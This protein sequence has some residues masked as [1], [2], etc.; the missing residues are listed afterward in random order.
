LNEKQSEY[1][2]DI[3]NS[4]T[5]LLRLIND[6]LDLAKV[7]TGK[8]ELFTETF[9]VKSSIDE[10]RSVIS[11][12]AKKKNIQLVIDIADNV[13]DIIAD[14]QKLKQVLYNLLSNAVKFTPDHG[15][16]EIIVTLNNKSILFQ[17]RDNG[18]GIEMEDLKHLFLPFIQLD[19]GVS[20]KH[21]GTGLGL[22][23]TK[24]L[25]EL[26]NG[27][28]GVQSEL[29]KGSMFTVVLPQLHVK[30]MELELTA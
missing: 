19:S 26:Q 14:K 12:L 27:T 2:N 21:E 9:S 17:I 16:V 20:R 5:H 29:G 4:G 7:E 28:V 15:K 3:L 8:M 25:V 22:A 23:L 1:L 13:D 10:M 11:S 18:I 6:V 24:K 30:E